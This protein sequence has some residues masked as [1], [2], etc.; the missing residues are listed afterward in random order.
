MK[1]C[2]CPLR[3]AWASS[4]LDA[5]LAGGGFLRQVADEGEV[6]PVQS[7]AGQRQQHRHRP[8]QGPHLDAQLVGGAHH[9]TAR[10]GHR[11]HA[12]FADQAHVVALQRRRQQGGGV[13]AR[14]GSPGMVAFLV[15]RTR[16]FHDVLR[17]QRRR[18]RDE[19]VDALEY[20]AGRARV[21][22]HPVHQ[23]GGRLHRRARQHLFQRHG[24]RRAGHDVAGAG[25][26]EIGHRRQHRALAGNRGRQNHVKGGKPVARHHQQMPV[27]YRVQIAH[28]AA[29][30]QW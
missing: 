28:L 13:V 16:Q 14:S 22:A 10:V 23:P 1:S 25:E 26:P 11:G 8:H 9:R 15:R 24:L 12:G 2:V 7:A 29:I 3:S 27:I 19:C 4:S 5:L 30:D 18:Q 6:L 21:L 20:R 17:L